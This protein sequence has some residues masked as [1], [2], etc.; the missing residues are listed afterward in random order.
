[1]MHGTP[2]SQ[3]HDLVRSN[4]ITA[5]QGA[6]LLE[7]RRQ[8]QEDAARRR[9]RPW[10]I[11]ALVLLTILALAD[12]ARAEEIIDAE[13]LY[14]EGQAAYDRNDYATA[15]AKWRTSLQLSGEIGLLFNIA[16][17]QRLA[18]DCEGALITYRRFLA[19]T[20]PSDQQRLAKDLALELEVRCG[21]P[22]EPPTPLPIHVV[23]RTSPDVVTALPEE[24]RALRRA[25]VVTGVAG[26]V[27][28][29]T[30][31]YLGHHGRAI[32]D[33][34]TVACRNGCDWSTLR[35]QDAAGRRDVAIGIGLDAMGS[36]G[37]LAGAA[38]YYFG[39]RAEHFAVTPHNGSVGLTWSARW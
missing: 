7:F 38:L 33:A 14:L 5:E 8:L 26:S 27:L 30:G 3:V 16:Q 34:V 21:A 9:R 11:L 10:V 20:Q 28:I 19:A 29:A 12:V 18:G 25:G 17:A 1:M 13:H 32:G 31:L 36:I 23:T 24:G 4:R 6:M 39:D 35:S 22:P 15:I 2:I 37:L